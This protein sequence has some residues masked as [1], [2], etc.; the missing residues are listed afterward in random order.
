MQEL[1]VT[2]E[3]ALEH[4]LTVEEFARIKNILGRIPSFTELG[5]F[6][7]MWSEHCS[8]KNSIKLL[9]TLPRSGG[10]L[11]VEAGEENA[12]LVDIGDG[13]AVACFIINV[14]AVLEGVLPRLLDRRVNGLP[15]CD[16]A[17]ESAIDINRQGS[18][19]TIGHPEGDLGRSRQGRLRRWDGNLCL[20]GDG[21]IGW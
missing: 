7:V 2:L 11:L 1:E 9:K 18:A 17:Q 20:C 12:G 19:R 21:G 4:G 3:L 14:F 16:I 5:I 13:L 10:R 8:Y 15:G 6:S